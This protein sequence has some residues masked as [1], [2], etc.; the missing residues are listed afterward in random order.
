MEG[1]TTG[2][3]STALSPLTPSGSD[4]QGHSEACRTCPLALT[5]RGAGGS[6]DEIALR[7][8]WHMRAHT[9]PRALSQWLLRKVAVL[10]TAETLLPNPWF[11]DSIHN[12]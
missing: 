6:P 1:H 2:F 9:F 11:R 10:K 7:S 4:R 12:S 3:D 5:P 8:P